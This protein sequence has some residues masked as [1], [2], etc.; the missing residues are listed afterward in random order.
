MVETGFQA[1]S[2]CFAVSITEFTLAFSYPL[3]EDLELGQVT[4]FFPDLGVGQ[5]AGRGYRK[6]AEPIIA[7]GTGG[8]LGPCALARLPSAVHF[9]RMRRQN[10]K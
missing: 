8:A 6:S 3:P 7:A 4:C 10:S 2:L 5:A 9:Y 1:P